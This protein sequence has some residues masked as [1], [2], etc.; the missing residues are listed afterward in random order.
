MDQLR[1]VPNAGCEAS[2]G[3]LFEDLSIRG[4]VAIAV[5]HVRMELLFACRLI[6]HC[7]T[8]PL[9]LTF[10]RCVTRTEQYRHSSFQCATLNSY[11]YN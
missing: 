1:K 4:Y 9:L 7:R 6:A 8:I 5:V 10:E 2:E 3:V 11:A